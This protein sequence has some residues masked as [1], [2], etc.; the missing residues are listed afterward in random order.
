MQVLD[1]DA[2][3][4][5]LDQAVA[6]QVVPQLL[7]RATTYEEAYAL[8]HPDRLRAL[9]LEGLEAGASVLEEAVEFVVN[10]ALERGVSADGLPSPS[11]VSETFKHDFVNANSAAFNIAL[12]AYGEVFEVFHWH[13]R[14]RQQQL[15]REAEDAASG[16]TGVA[17]EAAFG[18]LGWWLTQFTA[19]ALAGEQLAQERADLCNRCQQHYILALDALRVFNDGTEQR[20][21]DVALEFEQLVSRRRRKPSPPAKPNSAVPASGDLNVSAARVAIDKAVAAGWDR[22]AAELRVSGVLLRGFP[23]DKTRVRAG[24]PRAEM[25]ETRAFELLAAAGFAVD[26]W[27]P[28][29]VLLPRKC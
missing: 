19:G 4:D 17:M 20:A 26:W 23:D 2:L 14:N 18:D 5:A 27:P 15:R 22:N 3:R 28:P 6:R 12:A 11:E 25:E 7:Q 29:A 8:S 24:S 16:L 9:A 13:V 10:D 1:E 21:F